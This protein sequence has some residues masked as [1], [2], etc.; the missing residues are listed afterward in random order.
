MNTRS[1]PSLLSM[2]KHDGLMCDW[3]I[4]TYVCT[5]LCMYVC[6]PSLCL[7]VCVCVCLCVLQF[8]SV[9]ECTSGIAFDGIA[10]QGQSLKI[11]RPKDYAPIPGVSGE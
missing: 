5:Y 8:R 1:L 3:S 2:V 6:L 7:C 4:A 10:F 9:E 11:R